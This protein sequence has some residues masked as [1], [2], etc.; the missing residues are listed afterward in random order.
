LLTTVLKPF[1]RLEKSRNSDTG[2]VG[3]G[4]SVAENIVL[5]HGGT[6]TLSNRQ[7]SGLKAVIEFVAGVP[8]NS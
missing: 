4:L 2:G 5:A 8:V 7:A 1:F 3:L 6:L